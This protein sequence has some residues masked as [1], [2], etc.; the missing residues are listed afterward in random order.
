[1][2]DKSANPM[3]ELRI[4]KLT[5]NICTGESGDRL[6]KAA[7]VSAAQ[8]GNCPASAAA[9]CRARSLSGAWG[10]WPGSRAVSA[11]LLGLARLQPPLRA[12]TPTGAWRRPCGAQAAPLSALRAYAATCRPSGP[13]A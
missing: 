2:A 7:K 13:I 9:G 4:S 6:Q 11:P 5:L 1:M 12:C 3:R 8:G 10:R